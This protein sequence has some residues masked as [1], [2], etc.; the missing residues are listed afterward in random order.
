MNEVFR[1]EAAYRGDAALEKL[2]A[3]RLVVCGA[4][5]L[6]SLLADNLVRQGV[7]R[8]TVIDSDRVEAHNVGTQLYRR[9][10]AGAYK[11]DALRAHCYRAVGVEIETFARRLDERTAAKILR[12]ADLVIDAFDNSASRELVTR[13]CRAAGLDCLHLGMN[14]A[15]GEVRWNEDYRVPADSALEDVCAVPLARNLILLVVAAGSEAVLRFLIENHKENYAITLND[16]HID[17]E[18][19]EFAIIK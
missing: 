14:A 1:H 7:R 10:D 15:Y 3:A 19:G 13:F 8:L 17:I 12:G 5:A 9:E 16:L 4:G 2:G 18:G 11:V 6:G